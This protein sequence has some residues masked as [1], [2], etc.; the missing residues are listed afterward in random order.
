MLM[1]INH[2]SGGEDLIICITGEILCCIFETNV[3]VFINDTS[4]KKMLEGKK[5]ESTLKK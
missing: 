1:D 4:I 2:T 3:K 5:R